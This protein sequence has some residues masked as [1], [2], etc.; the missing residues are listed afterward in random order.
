TGQLDEEKD[1][2]PAAAKKQQAD[3]GEKKKRTIIKSL[4]QIVCPSCGTGHIVKGRTAYGCSNYANGCKVLFP[5]EQYPAD[6]TPA[7]LATQLKKLRK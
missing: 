2:K 6:L 1:R 3:G 5:F 4:D 7:K